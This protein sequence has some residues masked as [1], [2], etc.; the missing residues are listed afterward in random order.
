M[1]PTERQMEFSYKKLT[2]QL[3]KGTAESV[4][5]YENSLVQGWSGASRLSKEGVLMG[6]SISDHRHR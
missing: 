3:G 2:V 5:L 6:P 1:Q 4:R